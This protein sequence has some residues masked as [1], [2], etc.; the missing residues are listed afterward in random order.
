MRRQE[1]ELGDDRASTHQVRLPDELIDRVV[2]PVTRVLHV[3]S[4]W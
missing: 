4:A 3:E 2:E 1:Q